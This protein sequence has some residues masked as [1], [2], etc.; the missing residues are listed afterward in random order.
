MTRFGRRS[1]ALGLGA[2]ALTGTFGTAGAAAAR[3]AGHDLRLVNL[4]TGE[5]TAITY[6]I[7]ERLVPDA[8]REINHI[9]RDHRTDEVT[10]IDPGLLDLLHVLGRRLETRQ[11]FGIISGYR[12]PRTNAMLVGRGGGV[13]K[14][15]LHMQ[16]RA[17]DIR[18]A[19]IDPRQIYRA[20]RALGL[21]GVGLYT[22]SGFVHLDTGRVRYWGH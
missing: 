17:I 16:G 9:L 8:L 20:G 7:G 11:P 18:L 2:L 15:S 5:K 3:I 4:H 13:A 6:R 12:S 14:R 1:V 10:K 22:S 19:G 21:G